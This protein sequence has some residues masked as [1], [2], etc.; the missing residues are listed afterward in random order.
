MKGNYSIRLE[1]L[2]EATPVEAGLPDTLA[3]IVTQ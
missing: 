2:S 1:G 3:R